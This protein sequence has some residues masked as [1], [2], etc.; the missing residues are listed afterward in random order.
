MSLVFAL[1]VFSLRDVLMTN[2]ESP[3]YHEEPVEVRSGLLTVGDLASFPQSL[4]GRHST[5]AWVLCRAHL[6]NKRQLLI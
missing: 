1:F 5:T 6:A 3:L 4:Q 2:L